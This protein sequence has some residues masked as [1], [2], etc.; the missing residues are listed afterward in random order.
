ML[1]WVIIFLIISLVAGALGLTGLSE[2]AGGIAEIIFFFFLILFLVSI[3][4]MVTH[5]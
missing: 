4:L 5:Q 2:A 3:V 1:T